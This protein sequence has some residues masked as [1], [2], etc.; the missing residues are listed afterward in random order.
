MYKN[1]HTLAS[2]PNK[3]KTPAT[4]EA[5]KRSQSEAMIATSLGDCYLRGYKSRDVFR[6]FR[7]SCHFMSRSP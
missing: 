4:R 2:V 1:R 7:R 5:K 3:I 6:S